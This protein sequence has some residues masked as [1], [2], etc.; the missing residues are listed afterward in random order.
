MSQLTPAQRL[1]CGIHAVPGLATS[2]AATQGAYRFLSNERISLPMLMEPLLEAARTGV[3]EH[4]DQYAL[5]VHD[6]SQCKYRKHHRKQDRLPSGRG[7]WYDGYQLYS[8]LAVGDRHGAPLAPI[9]LSLQASDGVHC[10]RS[11]R[12]RAA[13]SVLDELEPCMQ[14]SAQLP[15]D[16]PLIHIIDAEAD[17]V[18]HFRQWSE[19]GYRYLVRADDRLVE[20][21]GEERKCSHW[22]EQCRAQ[23]E[24]HF[25]REVLYQGDPALQY[26]AE[27][28]VRLIRPGQQNRPGSKS[29]KRVP[30]PPLDLRLIFSEVRA[31]DGQLLATWYLLAH[32][33]SD[34]PASTIAL[35]YYWRWRIESYFKLLKSAGME[36][37]HWQQATADRVARRLIVA[38]MA[39]TLV[40][41]LAHHEGP[42]AQEARQ[43]LIRLSGRQMA[44]GKQ[45][46]MPALLS[47]LWILLAM[48]QTLEEYDLD[49][50]RRLADIA[51]PQPRPGP[52]P[53]S[54]TV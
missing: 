24:F 32:V 23:G 28:P 4:C 2:L 22:Q 52:K 29:R 38:S 40:W 1:A 47:G 34:V 31:A 50:L 6:W 48:L 36:L 49:T 13:A 17:S 46:T 43:L 45:Y 7:P 37:E 12:V 25:A 19:L 14:F 3:A 10:S 41:Q 5:V 15:W 35:W 54:K 33:N 42:Q 26:V 44:R 53:A 39:C 18:A 27:L 16:K 8:A 30:G 11:Y 9:A 21:Q 20:C 51:L